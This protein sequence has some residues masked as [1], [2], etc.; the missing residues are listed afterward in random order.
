MERINWR[1]RVVAALVISTAMVAGTLSVA[2]AIGGPD[3]KIY[4]CKGNTTGLLRVVPAGTSCLPTESRMDWD[5]KGEKGD[6]GPAGPRGPQ[7]PAGATVLFATVQ[8]DGTL[9]DGDAVSVTKAGVGA[10][11]VTFDRVVR[12]CAAVANLAVVN[13]EGPTFGSGSAVTYPYGTNVLVRTRFSNNAA[14]DDPFD[15]VVVC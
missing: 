12:H 3:T 5:Q 8:G 2:S 9:V 4:A 6:I 15:L 14:I 13:D 10:Y 11:H 1:G 7:G